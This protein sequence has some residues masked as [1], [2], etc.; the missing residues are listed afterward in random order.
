[1]RAI[2]GVRTAPE[3]DAP[4]EPLLHA[5]RIGSRG[6]ASGR[7]QLDRNFLAILAVG[8]LAQID[9]AMPPRPISRNTR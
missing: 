7:D 5:E 6:A 2:P 8:T 4:P 9:D 1:M 3:S